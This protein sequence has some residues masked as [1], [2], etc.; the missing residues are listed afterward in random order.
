MPHP[1]SWPAL[2]TPRDINGTLSHYSKRQ[3]FDM[4]LKGGVKEDEAMQLLANYRKPYPGFLAPNDLPYAEDEEKAEAA[5]TVTVEQ[6]ADGMAGQADSQDAAPQRL[7]PNRPQQ[8]H[9]RAT[10]LTRRRITEDTEGKQNVHR[11][12]R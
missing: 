12:R 6:S 5:A 11:F 9:D 8:M 10:Q 4:L 2:P 3:M 7:K 1:A